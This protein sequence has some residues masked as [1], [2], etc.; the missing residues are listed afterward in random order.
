MNTLLR[1][2]DPT[3]KRFVVRKHFKNELVS[4]MNVRRLAGKRGPAKRTAAFA[5]QRAN[6]S[7]NEPRKVVSICQT[8]LESECADVVAIVESDRAHFLQGEHAFHVSGD[9]LHGPLAIGLG[10]AL[11]Q[12][13]CVC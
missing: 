5:K 4:A 10:I 7:G 1:E 6:V 11:A 3:A 2:L 12:F 9:G 8:L 13:F